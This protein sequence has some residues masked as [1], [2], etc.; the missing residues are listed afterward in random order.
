ME[1]RTGRDVFLGNAYCDYAPC[2]THRV[3]G[4]P[5]IKQR[6]TP[7]LERTGQPS[8]ELCTDFILGSVIFHDPLRHLGS[9]QVILEATGCTRPD[10]CRAETS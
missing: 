10:T 7:W 1:L 5:S 3:G 9:L 6:L 2:V 4:V 8:K